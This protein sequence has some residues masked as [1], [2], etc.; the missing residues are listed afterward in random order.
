ML[1]PPPAA[2]LIEAFAN[3]LNLEYGTDALDTP[4]HT[5]DWLLTQGLLTERRR[6]SSD[7]HEQYLVL[8]AGIREQLGAHVG[9]SPA[10]A[11]VDAADAI[12]RTLP[13]HASIQ[14]APLAPSAELSPS[15]RPLAALAVAWTQIRTTGDSV[16][17]K[18]CAEHACELVFWD[19][20][21]NHSRRWC[22]MR[23]CGN[24]VK[25]RSYAARR[26]TAFEAPD[27]P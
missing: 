4:G 26:A 8:R 23:V 15:L 17:L 10:V 27:G 12:L 20:S 21:K 13:L 14:A 3:T 16:R 18:R 7:A 1:E 24:R 11:L 6:L 5:T 25:T 9:G 2:L 22:S 19:L